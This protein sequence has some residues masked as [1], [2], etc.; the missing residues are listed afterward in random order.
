MVF[1][2]PFSS[3]S[4]LA[5]LPASSI[6]GSLHL[7]PCHCSLCWNG[8]PRLFEPHSF[9]HQ[10]N[11]SQHPSVILTLLLS[12]HESV[13][14]VGVGGTRVAAQLRLVTHDGAK[15]RGAGRR[16]SSPV[17]RGRD[18]LGHSRGF[19]PD[20]L[21]SLECRGGVGSN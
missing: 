21:P 2:H 15:L 19:S 4:S 10:Q 18:V 1:L 12:D 14:F 8:A 13:H 20:K 6:F 5:A 7:N 9:W 3:T 17:C 11:A 16:L